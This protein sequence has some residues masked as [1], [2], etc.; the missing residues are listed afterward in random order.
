MRTPL[1]AAVSCA[2]PS[3]PKPVT[4]VTAL[5]AYGRRVS[6]ASRLSVRIAPT[7]AVERAVGRAPVALCLQHEPGAE[8]L[9]EEH[10]VA[11]RAPLLAQMPSGWTVPTTASPYFG[12]SSRIVCPP[13][14]IAPAARTASSAPASTSPSTSIGSSSGNAVTDERQQRRATH[15][16]DVVERVRGRDRAEVARVVDHRWEEVDR[17]HE[18]ALVVEPVHGR[19]VRRV[20]PDEQVCGVGRASAPSSASSRAAEYLAAHPP[21]RARLVSVGAVTRRVYGRRQERRRDGETAS[22]IQRF[23][24]PLHE[25]RHPLT[26]GLR[27]CQSL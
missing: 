11:G 26:G 10:G 19:V 18:R 17:E 27:A 2:C 5:G 15:G 24:L 22:A 3:R 7:A 8:R 21:A 9:R 6:A 13:A 25:G 14:R 4:S 1:R 12:S 20:E 16:E 23:L